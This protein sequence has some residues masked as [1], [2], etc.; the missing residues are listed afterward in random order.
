MLFAKVIKVEEKGS[1]VNLATHLLHD[2]YR[3]RFDVAVLITGD[4]DLLEAMRIVSKELGKKVGVFNPQK[5]PC[6]MLLKQVDFYQ[7]I[8]QPMVAASQFPLTLTDK[9]G[10]FSKLGKW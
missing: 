5:H 6:Q 1:D 9:Y 10:T 4:T 7:Q 2:A 3:N 8:R